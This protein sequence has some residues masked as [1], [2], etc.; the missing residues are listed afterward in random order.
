[1]LDELQK[2]FKSL[3]D[4][5]LGVEKFVVNILRSKQYKEEKEQ[6]GVIETPAKIEMPKLDLEYKLESPMKKFDLT[7]KKRISQIEEIKQELYEDK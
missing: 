2:R 4:Y 7:P 3:L 5:D 6:L 1:M